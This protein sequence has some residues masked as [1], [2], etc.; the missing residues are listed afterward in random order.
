MYA[1]ILL[2]LLTAM[3][4]TLYLLGFNAMD[5]LI[6]LWILGEVFIGAHYT[7]FD[8]GNKQVGFAVAN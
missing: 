3:I 7:V 8:M 6:R 5:S 1:L 4:E 2:F